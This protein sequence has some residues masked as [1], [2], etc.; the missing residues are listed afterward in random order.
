VEIA[1]D[2]LDELTVDRMEV[3]FDVAFLFSIIM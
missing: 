3:D 1:D 2:D